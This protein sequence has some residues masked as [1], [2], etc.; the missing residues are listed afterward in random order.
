MIHDLEALAV[1]GMAMRA[2][3]SPDVREF[4]RNIVSGRECLTRLEGDEAPV[5]SRHDTWVPVKG[6]LDHA[7]EFDADFF[8]FSPREAETTDPQQRVFLQLVWHALEDAG[9]TPYGFGRVGVYASTTQSQYARLL[10]QTDPEY[11]D[12]VGDL[13]LRIGTD[14]DFLATRVAYK[15]DLHGP[16]VTVQSACSSSLVAV[17]MASNALLN[18][19]CDVAVA[20]G[21]TITLPLR[22]G[23]YYRQGSILSPDGHCR[24][25]DAGAMGTV[26]GN[27][28]GAV[29]LRR[30]DDAIAD[31]DDIYAVVLGTALNN[32]GSDKVGFTAPS[33]AGQQ[34]AIRA[35]LSVSGVRPDWVGLV[36]AHGT[37]TA[38]GD[39]IELSALRAVFGA[40]RSDGTWCG[41]SS[42]KGNV[43][44]LDSAAGIAG[45]IKA[46]CAV[47][48]GVV[49]PTVGFR[50]PNPQLHLEQSPFR[51]VTEPTPWP[52]PGRRIA[53]VSGFGVGGTNAHVV[54][55]EAPR[56]AAAPQVTRPVALTLSAR[57]GDALDRLTHVVADH[58]EAVA[59]IDLDSLEHTLSQ[60]RVPQQLRRGFVG[61]TT[62]KLV[63]AMRTPTAAADARHHNG[64]VLLFPGQGARWRS[65]GRGLA[66]LPV[67]ASVVTE[68]RQVLGEPQL[69]P[70]PLWLDL[71]VDE[72][73]TT[74]DVIQVSMFVHQFAVSE[75][76][77]THGVTPAAVVG[78]SVGELV[79][80]V[81][82]GVLSF[83]DGLRL[84]AVRGAAM[85]RSCPAGA[86]L[87]VALSEQE[88]SA[89]IDAGLVVSAV[90]G[91]ARC[92]V[93]GSVAGI[94]SLAL[95]LQSEGVSSRRLDVD[96]AF[97]SPDMRPAA[98]AMKDH[99]D[100]VPLHSPTIPM[101]S[102]MTGSMLSSEQA[103][104]PEFW[105][106]QALV[107]VRFADA[108]SALKELELTP[109]DVG[110]GA[111]LGRLA[112]AAEFSVCSP[113]AAED[114]EAAFTNCLVRL[115]VNGCAVDWSSSSARPRRRLHLAGYPF[116]RQRHWPLA[117]DPEGQ[118]TAPAPSERPA[119]LDDLRAEAADP[120]LRH[121]AVDSND[122]WLS[123]L[124][125]EVLGRSPKT[126]D[127]SFFD[128]GGDSLMAVQLL[129]RVA[130][131]AQIEPE[132]ELFFQTP[133]V[134]GLAAQLSTS[135]PV[136]SH[137]SGG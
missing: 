82:A 97:H 52:V 78:H 100:G 93:S 66:Q 125:S 24:A 25:F 33:S 114:E 9:H 77:I 128:L 20:G 86:M 68:A 132:L 55:A 65:M 7:D 27:G 91:P 81:R 58:L 70:V 99:L 101:A 21:I 38:L 26:P 64:V 44:H 23:Y 40:S 80:A 103:L 6:V 22:S 73:D 63:A 37:G 116:A 57:T 87:A 12:P 104:D 31:G 110:P 83:A 43:G 89:R 15:L 41:L 122:R 120:T 107:P 69:P 35:A 18:G 10:Q 88:L 105:A 108:L 11:Q 115:W 117:V 123:Q 59:D 13:L 75:M 85:R 60:G 127:E 126:S 129:S 109:V 124:F 50:E 130:E 90:N 71:A 62:E 98:A 42:T 53:G 14:S 56:Q 76:L 74:T 29:V 92:V 19:D 94:D 2:P 54:V 136:G 16:A 79:A 112:G 106:R 111:V 34:A 5:G 119:P 135:R 32:D 72:L 30:L 1:V 51:V 47:S 134:S 45:F 39:P 84:V 102:A 8:G 95:T 67:Y 4:W 96:R 118:R 121:E 113:I 46:V 61:R 48:A 28:G 49:P 3:L 36:E 17:H 137:R 133:T 131:K